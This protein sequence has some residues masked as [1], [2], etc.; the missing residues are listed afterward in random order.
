MEVIF[1]V[2]HK[3]L[4]YTLTKIVVYVT[5]EAGQIRCLMDLANKKIIKANTK[6][7]MYMDRSMVKENFLG[8]TVHIFKAHFKKDYFLE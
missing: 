7:N 6:A 3:I 1:K 2:Y 4:E 5:K 8:M